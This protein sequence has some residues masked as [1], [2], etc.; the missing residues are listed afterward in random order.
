M[1]M[2]IEG[3]WRN[4]LAEQ[5]A[6]AGGIALAVALLSAL[7][8]FFAS[9]SSTMTARAVATVSPDWQL[10]MAEGSDADSLVET[11]KANRNVMDMSVVGYAN[12]RGLT[13]FSGETEQTTGQAVAVGIETGYLAKFP[14]QFRILQGATTGIM[15]AQQ[16]AANLHARLGDAISLQLLNGT[17]IKVTV[18]GIVDLPFA[19]S[20]F[21]PVGA[22]AT[23]APRAPPDNVVILPMEQWRNS[24]AEQRANMPGTARAQIHIRLDHGVLPSDPVAA[25][26]TA[27]QL[28]NNAEAGLAGEGA[29]GNNLAVRLDGARSDALYMRVLFLFLGVPGAILGMLF[30]I[31]VTRSGQQRH[32]REFALLKSRGVGTRAILSITGAQGLSAAVVGV[33]AGVAAGTFIS[34]LSFGVRSLADS[35]FWIAWAAIACLTVAMLINLV[36]AWISIRRMNVIQT[37]RGESSA[38]P[39]VSWQ[40]FYLDLILLALALVTFWLSASTGY[41]IVVAPEGV[42]SATVD[43][44]AFLAPILLWIGAVLLFIRL[45]GWGLRRGSPVIALAIS[46]MARSLAKPISRFICHNRNATVRGAALLALAF[47]FAVSTAI[48]NTTYEQQATVDAMLTNGADV[49]ISGTP[50]NPAGPVLDQVRKVAGVGHAEPLMHRFAYVGNDLQDIYGID[51]TT[52]GAV[53]T[54]SNAYFGNRDAT[55]T[56][57]L[58]ARTKD[59]V[60]VSDETVADFQLKLGDTVNLRL[61]SGPDGRFS[62]VPFHF[63]GIVREFPTAPRDSFLVANASYL[64][65]KTG[66]P[67]AETILVKTTVPAPIVAAQLRSALTGR[68]FRISGLNEAAQAV[69]STLTAVDLK[70]LSRLEL[71]FALPL[72]AAAIGLVHMLSIA[73]R[74]RS[75]VILEALGATA[76]QRAFFRWSE[77]II[78]F[79]A[80]CTAGVVLGAALAFMLVKMMTGV[81]DPP[82]EWPAIPWLYLAVLLASS[83]ICGAAAVM[84][85]GD[86]RRLDIP[87]GLKDLPV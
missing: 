40:R 10:Q 14:E 61:Q 44:K 30:S 25:Y 31:A 20:F 56:L 69:G 17:E 73:E 85:T 76:R 38:S 13:S 66:N 8:V 86:G 32:L 65:A 16:T 21:Q 12:L 41:Q 42:P 4:R 3:L 27:R 2:W 15:L 19:D 34:L 74:R 37:L 33:A 35:W 43:Y 48:F 78:V 50:V 70:A 53:T 84:L 57:D 63:L 83:C 29:I 60:L 87:S 75:F 80:G 55:A 11:L 51:T 45:W 28:A 71:L 67:N 26:E 47:S 7:G 64:A 23:A 77:A 49:T 62:E 58:L 1:L 24:F 18:A 54:I 72:V 68:G 59:G 82:P 6:V 5:L 79:V 22:D 81:F 52:I 39:S 9:S 36:P 46:P